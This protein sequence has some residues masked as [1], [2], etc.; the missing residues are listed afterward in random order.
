MFGGNS[1]MILNLANCRDKPLY[2][3]KSKSLFIAKL[4]NITT[5]YSMKH[6]LLP[7]AGFLTLQN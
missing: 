2:R 1:A 3:R 7:W 4:N 5:D 6:A